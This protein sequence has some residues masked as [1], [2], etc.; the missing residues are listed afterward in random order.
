MHIMHDLSK[1]KTYFIFLFVLD[2]AS[3]CGNLTVTTPYFELAAGTCW[4]KTAL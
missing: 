4:H 3:S 2:G 1:F